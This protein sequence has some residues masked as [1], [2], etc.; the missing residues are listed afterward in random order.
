MHLL[1][2]KRL[3]VNGDSPVLSPDFR[4]LKKQTLLA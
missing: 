1:S 3:S 4:L 2:A